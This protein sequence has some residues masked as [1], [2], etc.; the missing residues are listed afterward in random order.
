MW[1]WV[2]TGKDRHR[3]IQ[4]ERGITPGS[5]WVL[6]VHGG[7]WSAGSFPKAEEK[8]KG[9]GEEGGEGK[10]ERKSI[11]GKERGKGREGRGGEGREGK[12][13]GK[14]KGEGGRRKGGRE[15]EKNQRKILNT[16]QCFIMQEHNKIFC[17]FQCLGFLS[18]PTLCHW[19]CLY[20]KELI[21][22]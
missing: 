7:I 2:R 9:R 16:P 21:V 20:Q 11:K 12:D 18:H 13:E 14:E 19:T 10:K 17:I 5:L 15:G 1:H 4:T 8:R 3:R 22:M 6:L